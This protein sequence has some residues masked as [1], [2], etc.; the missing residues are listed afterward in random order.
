MESDIYKKEYK[1][2]TIG[3]RLAED[4]YTLKRDVDYINIYYFD[5]FY[6]LGLTDDIDYIIEAL[7]SHKLYS[8]F[9]DKIMRDIA[10]GK[11]PKEKFI[12]KNTKKFLKNLP[13]ED[14]EIGKKREL[15]CIRTK[16]AILFKETGEKYMRE[17]KIYPFCPKHNH[18]ALE[19]CRK[20]LYIAPSQIA[21]DIDK[22]I[23]IYKDYMAAD[24]SE[25]K[26]MH[27]KAADAI[28]HF[29]NGVEITKKE[30][31]KYFVLKDGTIK[32]NPKSVNLESYSRLGVR[33]K[34]TKKEKIEV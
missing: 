9:S 33:N 16:I 30:L 1:I 17:N 22:F 28:N 29:F 14:M 18:R 7:N 2:K 34:A 13:P 25:T 32:I 23:E 10:E 12:S 26:E 11:T 15:R 27:Q 19:L 20:A 4:Y 31:S 8:V 24:E 21:I 6:Y 5:L 3:G